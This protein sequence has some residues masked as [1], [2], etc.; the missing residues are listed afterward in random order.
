M[1]ITSAINILAMIFS[2][3]LQ[4]LVIKKC[5][6]V[7]LGFVICNAVA[8]LGM[9]LFAMVRQANSPSH[10]NLNINKNSIK[11]MLD[12]GMIKQTQNSQ[13]IVPRE[14]TGKLWISKKC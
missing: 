9:M 14:F 8:F 1:I 7:E 2:I 4:F 11:I 5:C 6:N 12:L 3:I 10:Y 13:F